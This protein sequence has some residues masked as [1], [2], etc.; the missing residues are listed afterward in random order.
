MNNNE[1]VKEKEIID[2]LKQ[3]IKN[4]SKSIPF[5]KVINNKWINKSNDYY[6]FGCTKEN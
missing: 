5:E 1:F 2:L 4:L 3:P 6:K